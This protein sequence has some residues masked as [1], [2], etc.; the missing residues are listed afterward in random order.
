MR[1]GGPVPGSGSA[2]APALPRAGRGRGIRRA[3]ASFVDESLFGSPAGAR[4]EP[5]GFSPPWAAAAGP[6]R[7]GFRPRSKCRLRSHTPSFCDESL[8]GAKPAGPAW[9]APWLRK[10]DIAKLHPLLW[11]PPPA[12]QPSPAPRCRE[13]PLRAVHPPTSAAPAA[14]GSPVGRCKFSETVGQLLKDVFENSHHVVLARPSPVNRYRVCRAWP[15]AAAL[16]PRPA[17][18]SGLLRS[19]LTPLRGPRHSQ[20]Q[21]A[22]STPRTRP[23]R[24]RTNQRPRLIG[25]AA[26]LAN[27]EAKCGTEKEEG[28]GIIRHLFQG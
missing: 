7:V 10:E 9:A 22:L 2:P 25:E 20:W 12:P 6:G 19:P 8:F 14:A 13:T 3:R 1:A 27:E 24:S 18:A 11:S 21:S 16:R 4:P 23:L 15:R 5:P 26:Q 28:A 17:V